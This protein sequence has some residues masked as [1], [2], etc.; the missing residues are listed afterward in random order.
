MTVRRKQ[1]AVIAQPALLHTAS[2]R[3]EQRHDDRAIC[4]WQRR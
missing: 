3:L 1:I 4:V 2:Q